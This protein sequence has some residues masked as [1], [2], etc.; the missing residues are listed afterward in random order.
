MDQYE[1]SEVN[2]GKN[3]YICYGFLE[4]RVLNFFQKEET[5]RNIHNQNVAELAHCIIVYYIQELGTCF[6]DRR[7]LVWNLF[8][9]GLL[10]PSLL[11]LI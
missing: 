5:M 1:I 8:S 10:K 3:E 7:I 11:H 4:L 9:L 6:G 2:L